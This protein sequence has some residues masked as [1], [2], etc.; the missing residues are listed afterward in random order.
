MNTIHTSRF[1]AVWVLT[2]TLIISSLNFINIEHSSYLRM[3][4]QTDLVVIGLPINEWWKYCAI[5]FYLLVNTFARQANHNIISPY[6]T[7]VVQNHTTE[8]TTQK[9]AIPKNH[10]YEI[11][12]TSNIYYWFDWLLYLNILLAQVD[13][14]IYE[15]V[16]ELAATIYITGNYMESDEIYQALS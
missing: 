6:I 9:H 13:M 8:A 15:I 12:I 7:L 2:V 14:V 4:P 11:V 1:I 3:G 16:A 10:V 5:V